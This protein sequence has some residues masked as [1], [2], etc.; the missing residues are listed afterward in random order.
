MDE[1]SPA[2]AGLFQMDETPSICLSGQIDEKLLFY[3]SGG[4]VRLQ[5]NE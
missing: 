1:K 3:F 5:P 4:S 2:P